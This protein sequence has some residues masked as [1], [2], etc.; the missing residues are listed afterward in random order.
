MENLQEFKKSARLAF[1]WT[2]MDPDRAA[3]FTLSEHEKYLNSDL[4]GMPEEEKERYIQGFKKHFGAWLGAHSRCASSFVT[5]GSGFNTR[6]AEK[7]NNSERNKYEELTNFRINAKRAIQRK[8]NNAEKPVCLDE[9][10]K[11]TFDGGTVVLN[12]SEDRIQILY[13]SKPSPEEIAKL[14]SSAF[15]W[16]PRFGAWQRQLT[17]NGC[18]AVSNIVPVQ[19]SELT[20]ELKKK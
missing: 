19:F 16:S 6:R 14:K 9:S 2:S 5:G 1:Y 11:F 10:K 7:A 8:I 20:K 17:I 3:G 13:D 15:R 18:D 4:E 12:Y